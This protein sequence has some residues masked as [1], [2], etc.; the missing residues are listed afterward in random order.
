[1]RV[2]R[3]VRE[4]VMLAMI[5]HPLRD[6]ALHRHAAE[7][8]EQ[9]LDRRPCLEALVREEAVEADRRSERAADVQAREKGGVDPVKADLP[10]QAHRGHEPERGTT[11]A[12][13]VTT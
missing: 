8:R 13:S 12:T 7:D 10:E 4:R 11:T 9:R 5:G 2:A 6:R 3:L 1:M